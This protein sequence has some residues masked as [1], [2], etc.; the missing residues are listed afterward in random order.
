MVLLIKI[1]SKGPVI[2]TQERIGIGGK[3]FLCYKFRTMHHNEPRE[4]RPSMGTS[5]KDKRITWIGRILRATN[6]DELPQ[7]INVLKGEMSVAGPRP[8]MVEEDEAISSL[9]RKYKIRRFMN[10]VFSLTDILMPICLLCIKQTNKKS[11]LYI[12]SSIL[13]Y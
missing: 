4:D 6:L 10:L 13:K 11:N 5:N 9:L 2:Y 7:F 8:H 1:S 3:P 12:S